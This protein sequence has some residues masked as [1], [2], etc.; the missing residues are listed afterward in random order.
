LAFPLA[1]INNNV[2]PFFLK[3][4]GGSVEN[5]VSDFS[6]FGPC[7]TRV[8]SGKDQNRLYRF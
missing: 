3:T 4:I 7:F 5:S 2:S 1:V 8:G 6:L